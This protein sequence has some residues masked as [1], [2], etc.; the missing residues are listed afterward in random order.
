MLREIIFFFKLIKLKKKLIN[1]IILA[2]STSVIIP[3]LEVVI[4]SVF[5]LNL[6]FLINEN[7]QTGILN[8]I[9]EWLNLDISIKNYYQ[10]TIYSTLIVFLVYFIY[11]LY[12]YFVLKV[13]AKIFSEVKRKTIKLLMQQNMDT[14]LKN[15][16]SKQIH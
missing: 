1:E 14:Y 10:I 15:D 7:A 13:G 4:L 11:L 3:I 16:Q 8:K 6:N 2:F 5:I 9:F 12:E